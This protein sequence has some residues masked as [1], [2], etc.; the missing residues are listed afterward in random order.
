MIVAL[1]FWSVVAIGKND[2]Y[3]I[4]DWVPKGEYHSVELC[5]KA[6]GQLGVDPSRARC[7]IVKE[8]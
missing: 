7:V 3:I 4:R 6:I 1:Y 5:Q 8:K 2:A